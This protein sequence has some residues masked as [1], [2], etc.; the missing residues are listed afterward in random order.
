[1]VISNRNC[2]PLS[3]NTNPTLTFRVCLIH[4][5]VT[6]REMLWSTVCVGLMTML[7]IN[8]TV[9]KWRSLL[10]VVA[11]EQGDTRKACSQTRFGLCRQNTPG[12]L[13]LWKHTLLHSILAVTLEVTWVWYLR[14]VSVTLEKMDHLHIMQ[15]FV[16]PAKL[17][18]SIPSGVLNRLRSTVAVSM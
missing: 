6:Q 14:H 18:H 5:E 9:Y 12:S 7:L 11:E 15:N 17:H 8:A 3:L 2:V 16:L 1:M 4:T 10:N 13:S